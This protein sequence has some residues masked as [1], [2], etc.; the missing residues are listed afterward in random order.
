M[1]VTQLG[2]TLCDPMDCRLPVSSVYVIFQARMWEWVAI[3]FF[4]GS[5]QPRDWIQVSLLHC[6]QILY[7]LY[8]SPDRYTLKCKKKKKSENS[9]NIV[10]FIQSLSMFDIFGYYW[11]SNSLLHGETMN[12][13]TFSWRPVSV[14]CLEQCLALDGGQCIFRFHCI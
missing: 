10:L 12:S 1:L 3:A 13:M 8:L 6:R 5:S 7:H 14:Q 9:L 4:R 11:H 2:L